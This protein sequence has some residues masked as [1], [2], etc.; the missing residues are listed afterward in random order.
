MR[1][2]N[3]VLMIILILLIAFVVYFFVG[4][5][6]KASVSTV[7][8][9]AAEYPDAFASIQN[10]LSAHAA[11]QQFGEISNDASL[12][13]LIDMNITLANHGLFAAE[14]VDV[15]VAGANGDVA[16]YSLTGEGSDVPARA[17][18]QINLKLIT[19]NPDAQR[20]ITMTYYIHGMLRT[21]EVVA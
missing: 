13:T 4:G 5:T 9:P 11:P 17:T 19:T 2:T 20:R 15:T 14:W 18:S 7:T 10:V 12:Y 21:L 6:L 16:V 1:K 3:I 8:A